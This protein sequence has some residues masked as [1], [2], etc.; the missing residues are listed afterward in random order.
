MILDHAACSGNSGQRTRRFLRNGTNTR[1][2]AAK[3]R[4]PSFC[5]AEHKESHRQRRLRQGVGD[6]AA[7]VEWVFMVTP[8]PEM[9]FFVEQVEYEPGQFLGVQEGNHGLA[10]D[11]V[12]AKNVQG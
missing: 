3:H 4:K 12:E 1:G 2:L 8:L 11:R 6:R 5:W 7:G 10:G 9:V